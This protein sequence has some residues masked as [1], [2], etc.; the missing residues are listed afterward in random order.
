[1]K[2]ARHET[3]A[4]REG[5]LT[6]GFRK[7]GQEA[8][9]DIF[10]KDDAMEQLG[11]GSNMVRSLRYW[12]QTTG[13]A[14]E[15]K[16]KERGQIL[17]PGFGDVLFKYDRYLEFEGSLWLLHYNLACDKDGATTWYW[18]FN[19]FSY[20]EF[21]E[22]LFLSELESW[23]EEQG[24]VV[25][26]GS[27]KRDYDCFL[28]TYMRNEAKTADPEE[29]LGCPLQELGLVE[30]FSEKQKA[31]IYR[32]TR[33][34]I[35]QIDDEL[36]LYMIVRFMENRGDCRY[37]SIEALYSEPCSIGRILALNYDE[38]IRTLEILEN[39][40]LLTIKRTAGLNQVVVEIESSS[41]E[42]LERYYINKSGVNE[43]D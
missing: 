41:V 36:L 13:L 25:S 33:R 42:I 10:S 28:S 1:M 8:I 32:I 40:E 4:F 7:I 26:S 37:V 15:I 21:D 39:K 5:W 14:K 38:L 29:H 17:T 43:H 18:F 27:L 2:F 24:E 23:V 19:H 11:I 34:N 6:K 22:S 3:F 31:K 12:M 35:N 9:H 16:G 20:R 30:L